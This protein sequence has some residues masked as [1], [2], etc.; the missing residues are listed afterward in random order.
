MNNKNLIGRIFLLLFVAFTSLSIAQSDYETVQNFKKD[1]A[2]VEQQIRN[3]A[4][5]TDLNGI[6]GDLQK[7]AMEYSNQSELLDKAL[8]PQKFEMTIARLNE[9]FNQKERNFAAAEVLEAE[10]MVLKQEVD[11]LKVMNNVLQVSFKEL[12]LQF[13]KS[14]KETS[15]LNKVVADLKS[16]LHKRDLLVMNMVDS[17][18]PPVMREKPM[19]SSED[20]D[21]ITSDVEKDNILVNV[22]TT[23]GDNIKYLDLTSLQATDISEI[24]DQQTEFADTWSKIGPRLLEVYA[25]DK[26]RARE[27]R[28]IDSLFNTWTAAVK[29]EAWE[30]IREVF[31]EK[32]IPLNNFSDG[33]GFAQSVNQYIEDEKNNINAVPEED[34]EQTFEEF[35]EVTWTN[36]IEAN[37]TPF[38]V[39][40][41]MLEKSH[42]DIIEENIEVWRSELYPSKWWIWLIVLGIFTAGLALL[43]SRLKRNS[44]AL[45]MASE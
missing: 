28:E 18:M 35:A 17:L 23:I 36:E 31:A 10:V 43:I 22:K 45:E 25:D 12:E 8:Y 20:K 42:Q 29:Q 44:Q 34:A 1:C 41:G 38:L 4:S 30:S 33:E 9:E 3:A 2:A 27:V 39:E 26:T 14:K 7:L 6:S 24:L 13:S 11:T 5:T 21:Q 32:G 37:W 16:S 40:N 19:L 15:R